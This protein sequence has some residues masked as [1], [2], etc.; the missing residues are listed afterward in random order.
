MEEKGG[1]MELQGSYTIQGN[2]YYT[3]YAPNYVQLADDAEVM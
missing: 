3:D 2:Q 1:V